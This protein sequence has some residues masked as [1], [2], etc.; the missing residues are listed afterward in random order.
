[1]TERFPDMLVIGAGSAEQRKKAGL[2][3][4]Y[5]GNLLRH[6]IAQHEADMA[7]EIACPCQCHDDANF[8]CLYT[9]SEALGRVPNQCVLCS[10]TGRVTLGA[11]VGADRARKATP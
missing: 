11:I 7:H 6:V 4:W 5:D 3:D 8:D 2:L 1:M 9:D 10:G